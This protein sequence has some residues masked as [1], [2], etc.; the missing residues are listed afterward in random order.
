M[1]IKTEKIDFT[2]MEI[3]QSLIQLDPKNDYEVKDYVYYPYWIFEYKINK[4][5][6]FHPLKGK[7]GC[8]IDGVNK[9]GALADTFPQLIN[10]KI[11]KD[12]VI[13]SKLSMQEAETLAKDF[14]Y[15]AITSKK[16]VMKVPN[17]NP[18]RQEMFY[19]PYWIVEGVLNSS[20]FKKTFLI[21]VDA[22]SGKYHPL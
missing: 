16:K 4:N 11:I 6:F 18:T 17:L 5:S 3:E 7:V 22:I 13:Q 15:G 19:R 21:T 1:L 12:K 20:R 10:S 2:K 14:L 9:A 8:S